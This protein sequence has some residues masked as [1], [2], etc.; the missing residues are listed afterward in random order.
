MAESF[1]EYRRKRDFSQ[2]PEP[3]T[4]GRRRQAG[5]A[6]FVVH[7]HHARSRHFDLRLQVGDRLCSWAVPKGPSLDPALKRLAVQVEDHPLSYGSFEGTIPQG[8]YGAG[9]V[10]IWDRGRWIPERDARRALRSGHLR[11]SL[12]GFRLHGSWSLVRTRLS[13]KQPQWLLMK[14]R[15]EAARAGD[16]ADD[17]PLS[18][19]QSQRSAR[20]ATP[21]KR[22]SRRSPPT[23]PLP[24][25]VGLQLARPAERAPQG[26]GWLHEVKFDGYRVL[27]WRNGKQVR[28]TSRG[29]QDWT[30]K[31]SGV[32]AAMRALPCKRCLM[33]GELV[34]L[35]AAGRSTFEGLQRAFGGDRQQDL[36]VMVFDLL[37]LDGKDLCSRPQLARKQ[38]LHEL[39]TGAGAPLRYTDHI[40]GH[41]PEMAKRACSEG[42]EGVISKQLDAPYEQG[43]GGAW[44]KVKCVQSDEYAVVGYTRGKGAR[45]GLGSLLV[46]RPTDNGRGWR[47]AGRVGT[48]MGDALLHELR[49]RLREAATSPP[50]AQAPSNAQL[51]GAAPVWVRPDLVVE[52]QFRGITRDGLL[53]QAS[54]KGIREDR[55]VDSLR[56]GRRDRAQVST[57]RLA[58]APIAAASSRTRTSG[59]PRLTHPDRVLFEHPKITKGALAAFYG[60]IADAILPGLIGRPLMLLRCPD[61]ARGA[62]FFQKHLSRGFPQAVH[63]VK[64]I[65]DRQRW[66]CIDGLD[67]LLGL[68]QMDAIEYHTWGAT[69][70]DLDHA[71]RIVFDL[72]PAP[73]V[74][75]KD[76][77]RAALELRERLERVELASFVRTSGGKGLHVVVPLRPS[78][79]WTSARSFARA[80]AQTLASE[81]PQR[82][83][84]AAT[85]AR[86]SG[87][88]YIDHLRNGR[89]ATAIASYSL[90]NRPGAPMAVP[91]RWKELS[92]VSGPQQFNY[93]GIRRRL[94][95]LSADP[96]EGFRALRQSLPKLE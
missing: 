34:C 67:G 9:R 7:L 54:L 51:R 40:I 73:N 21:S 57:E 80:L 89:G 10:C 61:G 26:D 65:K 69:A 20:H 37:H 38:A 82:Y 68:V 63:E 47:Y 8:E 53:R 22:E 60:D 70:L 84:A 77:K 5:D 19:W 11:F 62:C 17:T 25:S 85:K 45:A 41:G 44:L 14:S 4:N 27:L 50:L 24:T 83:I 13:G 95:R 55:S 93:A 94:A 12:E 76:V 39:L 64:D 3:R 66:I 74:S 6:S 78:V 96:W 43:R 49:G 87:R 75:W 31:L 46:A 92:R 29:A 81:Q 72:D 18:E 56:P 42:L 16:K 36:M 32:A 90:R 91:L 48:G 71:D 59:G 30:R 23:A 86:R 52:V 15:D 35:D 28:V 1:A 33:D 2:T 79:D 88:V 58:R